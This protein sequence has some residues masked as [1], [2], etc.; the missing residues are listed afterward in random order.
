MV[1]P[2]CF[3]IKQRSSCGKVTKLCGEVKRKIRIILTRSVCIEVSQSQLLVLVN[4]FLSGTGRAPFMWEL[5][6]LLS[7]RKR[8]L[9]VTLKAF[10]KPAV[11]QML[12]SQNNQHV[13][14]TYFG[15]RCPELLQ[16]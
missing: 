7:G 11:S 6:L 3:Y 5:Y 4:V 1:K 9:R 16:C 2:T 13:K 15:V 8:G 14:A 12:L 10:E